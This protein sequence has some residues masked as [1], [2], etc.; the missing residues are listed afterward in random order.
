[1]GEMAKMKKGRNAGLMSR[2]TLLHRPKSL[3]SKMSNATSRPTSAGELKS[4][5]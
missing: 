1:M 2:A 3:Y 4:S 5:F